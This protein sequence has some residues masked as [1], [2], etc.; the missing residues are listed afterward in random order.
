MTLTTIDYAS[1]T[2][3]LKPGEF[4]EGT[5]EL[6]A[7]P[8]GTEPALAYIAVPGS[9]DAIVPA[10]EVAG[11]DIGD[12]IF[13]LVLETESEDH[14]CPLVS[15]R[16]ART[17]A[18][19]RRVADAQAEQRPV[20]GRVIRAV[21][22]GLTLDL[23]GLRAFLPASQIDVT[24]VPDF[25]QLV[26]QELEVLITE[27]ERRR[28][29]VV[30][31]RRKLIEREQAEALSREVQMLE[32]GCVVEGTVRAIAKFGVFVQLTDKLVGLIHASEVQWGRWS[33]EEPGLTV[34][35]T[36]AAQVLEVGEKNGKPRVALSSRLTQER[37]ARKRSGERRR[38]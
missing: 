22:G 10:S 9:S 31:S 34:G 23:F 36:L 14:G 13:A 19:W 2:R 17:E 15:V 11:C 33:S 32:V 16:R 35:E 25:E 12:L 38:K 5:L 30:V 29:N 1:Y 18:T 20:F 4:V 26:G 24:R 6:I 28:K 7:K 8:A 3:V 27:T 21:R 37:P